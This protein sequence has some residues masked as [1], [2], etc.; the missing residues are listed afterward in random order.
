MGS[1]H[2]SPCRLTHSACV[3]LIHSQEAQRLK[4]ALAFCR[5]GTWS[6]RL[7]CFS[8]LSPGSNQSHPSCRNQHHMHGMRREKSGGVCEAAFLPS[9]LSLPSQ[10]TGPVPRSA[11]A[12]RVGGVAAEE[13][14][15]RCTCLVSFQSEK[16]LPTDHSSRPRPT[17]LLEA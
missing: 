12:P 15:R 6:M 10:V 14:I 2:L 16:G 17:I 5:H 7:F 13:I 11:T 1:A 3:H 9:R 8:S 4:S